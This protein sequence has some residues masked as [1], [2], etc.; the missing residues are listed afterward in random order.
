MIRKLSLPLIILFAIACN[1]LDHSNEKL[2]QVEQIFVVDK[3]QDS[4]DRILAEY[5][6]LDNYYLHKRICYAENGNIISEL[7]FQYEDNQISSIEYIDLLSPEFSYTIKFKLDSKGNIME[8]FKYEFGVLTEHRKFKYGLNNKIESVANS[9]DFEY[10]KF[11]YLETE[12]ILKTELILPEYSDINQQKNVRNE[13]GIFEYD[14]NRKP[15]FGLGK[16]FQINPYPTTNDESVMELNLSK[17][18]LTKTV[19]SISYWKYTYNE[20]GLPKTI[21]QKFQGYDDLES[22]VLKLSYKEAK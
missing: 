11:S 17:N 8:D 19:H 15:N 6:Y 21:E 3:I 5:K 7:I 14:E 10:L 2:D 16:I 9:E 22:Q 20:Y 18:N 4:N 1:K 13:I 12:N